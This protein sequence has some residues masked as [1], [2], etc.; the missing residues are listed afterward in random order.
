AMWTFRV[1]QA[2]DSMSE[3]KIFSDAR[4]ITGASGGMIGAAYFR[5]LFLEK[6]KG[7]INSMQDAEYLENISN[8]LLNPVAVSLIVNDLFF[9]IQ[10]FS[11]GKQRY[12]KDRAYA[13]EKHLNENTGHVL[14]KNISDYASE[15]NNAVIPQMIFSPSLVNDGRRLIISALPVSYLT[16]NIEKDNFHFYQL[17]DCIEFGKFFS[18]YD[19]GQTRFT[20]VLRMSATFPYILPA[21][22][23]PTEPP[24][25]VMDA[26][27]RDNFG[28]K[29]TLRYLFI[30]RQW[31][32]ENTSGVVILNIRDTRKDRKR[33]SDTHGSILENLFS[34]VGNIYRNVIAV[35]E[36]E[37]DEEIEYAKAW[38]NTPLDMLSFELPSTEEDISLSWHLTS[39]EKNFIR[40]AV[41]LPVNKNNFEL[42]RKLLIEQH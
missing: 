40:H 29:T 1:L 10:K 32:E 5:E 35:Q 12:N 30:F 26:G 27:I 3:G 38:L 20:T 25:Q 42:L 33:G 21:V 37:T 28:L 6:E 7:K 16:A 14:E 31:I 24:T 36:Y 19:A 9:N 18:W 39:K 11:I 41:E 2:T 4:L 23:L 17:N 13:F 34:P 22:T 15:E 8:D